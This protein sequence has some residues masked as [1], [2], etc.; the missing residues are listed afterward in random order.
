[1]QDSDIVFVYGVAL[2]VNEQRKYN[3]SYESSNI[4]TWFGIDALKDGSE[5]KLTRIQIRNKLPNLLQRVFYNNTKPVD[6][7][8]WEGCVNASF[9]LKFDT[10][11]T[12]KFWLLRT[13]TREEE[14]NVECNKKSN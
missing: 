10:V 13:T 6:P 5:I 7:K 1:M 14:E 11:A 2:F 3:A 8:N 9:S 4:P 12:V